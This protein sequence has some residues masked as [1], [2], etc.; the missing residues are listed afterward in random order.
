MAKKVKNK[1]EWKL[2]NGVLKITKEESCYYVLWEV[3]RESVVEFISKIE[4]IRSF[5]T[6]G[7]SLGKADG[8]IDFLTIGDV[9]IYGLYRDCLM[10]R[11]GHQEVYKM[12]KQFI[13]DLI[14]E[15]I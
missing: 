15:E 10:C 8:R 11:N 9:S 14:G 5:P 4:S 13:I 2:Q 1:L 3:T 6:V 7:I 12:P